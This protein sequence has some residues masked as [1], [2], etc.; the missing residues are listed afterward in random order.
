MEKHISR[1]SSIYYLRGDKIANIPKNQKDGR[2]I[3]IE[4]VLESIHERKN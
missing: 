3:D 1:T 2:L 4:K